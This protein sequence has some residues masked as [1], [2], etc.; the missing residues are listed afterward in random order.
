MN[1]TKIIK[2]AACLAWAGVAASSA[3]AADAIAITAQFGPYA[4]CSAASQPYSTSFNTCGYGMHQWFDVNYIQQIRF[5]TPGCSSGNCQSEPATVHV[6]AVY[7][8]SRKVVSGPFI[9]EMCDNPGFNL[10]FLDPCAC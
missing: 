10:F 7:T 1:T 3:T 9:E 8:P 4:S 2:L 5:V 6:D